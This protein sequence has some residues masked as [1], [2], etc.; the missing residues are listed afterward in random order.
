MRV[1]I[2]ISSLATPRRS[3]VANYTA[4]LTEA[5]A[6]RSDLLV[7]GSFFNFLNRQ[8]EPNLNGSILREKCTLFPLRIY[9]K[10]SSY[11]LAWPFDIVRPS[12]DLTIHPNF[13]RWPTW[14]SRC[15]MTVIHDLT[16]LYRPDAVETKNLSHLQRVVPR[17]IKKSDF[18][19]TV[20]QA[21]KSEIAKEFSI[22]RHKI[23]VTEIPPSA[24]FFV[25]NDQEIHERYHIPTKNYLLFVGNLEPRKNLSTLVRAYRLLPIEVRQQYSLVIAGGTGWKFE[26]TQALINDPIDTGHICQIGYVDQADLPALFQKSSLFVFPSLYEGFGMPIVEALASGCKVVAADIPVLRESGGDAA[27][28]ANPYDPQDFAEKINIALGIPFDKTRADTQLSQFSWD[29]NVQKIIDA[30][31]E[32][33]K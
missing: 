8:P 10:F 27:I 3:G 1:R 15:V 31:N 12:V 14:R 22:D 20:S 33:I 24:D 17:A 28:Y 2:D 26:E 32:F 11:D 13:A 9:A 16:Y 4:L 30:Y 21:V 7:R 6:A 29:N 23:I 18:V 5:F 25:K 19:I